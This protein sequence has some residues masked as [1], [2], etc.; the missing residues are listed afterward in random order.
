[1]EL[2][3]SSTLEKLTEL[4]NRAFSINNGTN[5]QME[6]SLTN[7]FERSIEV[8]ANSISGVQQQT[9]TKVTIRVY[10]G[11]KLGVA[12]ATS[13]SP[14]SIEETVK[15]AHELAK[16]SPEDDKFVSLPEP[17][18]KQPASIK[19]LYDE[20]LAH[21][22]PSAVVETLRDLIQGAKEVHERANARCRFNINLTE[23]VVANSLG[24]MTQTATTSLN[25]F[26]FVSIP[27]SPQNV[28]V[29]ADFYVDRKWPKEFSFHELGKTAAEKA[30][31]MLG[32]KVGPSKKLPVILDERATFQTMSQI[33]GFGVNGYTVMTGTSYFAD[34]I[35][36]QLAN[37]ELSLWDDPHIEGGASSTPFDFE[38]VPTSK[39]NILEKGILQSYVTDS[40]TANALGLENTG[41]AG[42]GMRSSI[43]K[44]RIHQLQIREGSHSKE[45]MYEDLKEGVIVESG[46][47]PAGGSPQIS[48]Q[49]NRGFYVKNGKIQYPL[50]NTMLGS[51]VYE[52]LSG[53]VGISK[54]LRKEFGHQAPTIMIKEV[55]I[56]GAGKTKNQEP[57]ITMRAD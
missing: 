20:S 37:D 12:T 27:M 45:E 23:K 19:G 9:K 17:I 1:M 31:K 46:I 2:Q 16:L 29:G 54:E 40:Y 25:T 49:I 22:D 7:G 44:P 41:N 36:E 30:I 53:I 51:S 6:I 4:A 21:M 42:P 10:L 48:S 5:A 26:A 24:I 8:R 47:R 18:T 57:M 34:K 11:K 14:Q 38:G 32:A 55:S 56:A 13:L 35:G 43:P 50:K 15:T 33:F 39:V 3:Q 52:F 28:G